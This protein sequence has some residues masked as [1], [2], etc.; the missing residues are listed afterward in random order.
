MYALAEELDYPAL[1]VTV[2]AKLATAFVIGHR[3][4]S[5]SLKNLIDAVF[6]PLGSPARI[7]KD[8]NGALH[9]LVVAAVIAH[10]LLD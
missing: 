4:S 7:Y 5:K 1:K 8:D 6:P 9:D 2:F 3:R 10:D